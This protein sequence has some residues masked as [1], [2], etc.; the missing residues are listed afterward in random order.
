MTS[1]MRLAASPWPTLDETLL[2]RAALLDGCAALEAWDEFCTRGGRIEL[3]QGDA[4]RLLPQLYRNLRGLGGEDRSLGRLKGVYRHTWYANHLLLQAGARAVSLLQGNGIPTMIVG[5]MAM[6]VRQVRDV[7]ARPMQSFGILVQPHEADR[8]LKLLGS[9]GWTVNGRPRWRAIFST[10]HAIEL[11]E[12]GHARV[13]LQW[14]GML[15]D[16]YDNGLWGAADA[17]SLEGV[18][19]LAP[20]SVDLLLFSCARRL[21]WTTAP[22]RWIPDATLVLRSFGPV[23]WS[24][25]VRRARQRRVGLGLAELLDFL[26]SEFHV[27]APRG[28]LAELC[29]HPSASERLLHRIK[30]TAQCR[31]SVWRTVRRTTRYEATLRRPSG[32][33]GRFGATPASKARQG[34]WVPSEVAGNCTQEGRALRL[35][36]GIRDAERS[37]GS[38]MRKS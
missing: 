20:S 22:L 3:L 8:A 24:R 23:D 29:R 7:G 9:H 35:R 27:E 37:G 33:R 2:M 16:L 31:A 14:P 18:D 32:S 10:T 13:R 38:T 34:A 21:G 36:Q 12:N 26:V 28:V 15:S 30:T 17:V 1:A 4:Y 11:S 19:S 6:C 5:D 25:L